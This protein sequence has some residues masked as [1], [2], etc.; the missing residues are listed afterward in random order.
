MSK[1]SRGESA[2]G[3]TLS[4]TI[5]AWISVLG[6][7][8]VSEYAD[9]TDQALRALGG[10]LKH[11][12]RVRGLSQ[13]DLAPLIPCGYE[14]LASVEQGR[15]RPR[16]P[17]F[18][19]ADKALDAQGS[20]KA[21]EPSLRYVFKRP[22]ISGD[23]PE[24]EVRALNLAYFAAM[25]IPAVMQTEAYARATFVGFAPVLDTDGLN[26]LIGDQVARAAVLERTP[27]PRITCVI[28]EAALR[29]PIGG[30]VVFSEQLRRVAEISQQG[31]VSVQVL[32]LDCD[33][34]AGLAG[35]TL[36]METI[37][38]EHVAYVEHAGGTHYITAPREVSL[39]HQ[40]YGTLRAQAMNIRDSRAL[41][42][43]MAV[44][45]GGG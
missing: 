17:F 10:L 26:A 27:P 28:D 7:A 40:R 45:S 37:E 43:K 5:Q 31:H 38:Q 16:E 12:R 19:G 4:L 6:V 30:P 44:N 18:D 25:A 34:H 11:W 35:S 20:I 15:R 41:I 22:V 23:L 9:E 29:R 24:M 3:P 36:L 33:D 21:I 2:S 8:A 42:E 39:L 13:Q 32:P 14:F 1:S